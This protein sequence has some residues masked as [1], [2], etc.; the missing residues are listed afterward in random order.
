MCK[1]YPSQCSLD[2]TK[3]SWTNQASANIQGPRGSAVVINLS[4]N[5]QYATPIGSIL[6]I[7]TG[8]NLNTPTITAHSSMRLE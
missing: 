3:L 4:Y 2:T 6:H 7:L 8:G 5:F 1:T